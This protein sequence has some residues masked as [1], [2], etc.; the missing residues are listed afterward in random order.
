MYVVC[1]LLLIWCCDSEG[2]SRA[3]P[4][5]CRGGRMRLMVA[6]GSLLTIARNNPGKMGR[7]RFRNLGQ[8]L[9]RAAINIS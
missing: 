1:I 4:E 7:S 9:A 8:A 5:G 2:F 3:V 6:E